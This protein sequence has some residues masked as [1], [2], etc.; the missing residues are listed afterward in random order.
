MILIGYA[1]RV[2][3]DLSPDDIIAPD[4]AASGDPALLAAHC[5]ENIDSALAELV[6]EGDLLIVN[7]RMREGGD[8]EAAVLALQ[9]LGIAAVVC[10]DAAEPFVR[11]AGQFGMPLL[12][13]VEAAAAV[14]AQ[15]SVRLDLARGRIE[16]QASGTIWW[17]TP[18]TPATV[19]AVRRVQLLARMR[20]VVEDEGFAE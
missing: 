1:R 4:V 14:P 8:P 9:A 10:T 2:E 13:Q 5:L 20:R 18:C 11:L 15:S 7:G 6:R 12:V 19:E 16:D 17:C 3:H